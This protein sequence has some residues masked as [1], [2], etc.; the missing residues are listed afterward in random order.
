MFRGAIQDC[1][2][3]KYKSF[4]AGGWAMDNAALYTLFRILNDIKPRN[5]LEFGLG[6]SSKLIHQYVSY[7]ND[8]N[9][10]TVEHDEEWIKFFTNGLPGEIRLNISKHELISI[11]YNGFE[12]QSYKNLKSIT[13]NRQYD[14]IIVD[15]P[16]GS[17]H[18]SRSQII[19]LVP[20]GLTNTFCI[21]M[22]DSDRKGENETVQEICKIL[23]E[24]KIK[25]CIRKYDGEKN[26]H[27]IICSEN[28]KFLTSLL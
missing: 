1:E 24:N 11:N 6:Q 22:D 17:E 26:H 16:F 7:F 10:I 21:F 20:N 2:W 14:L 27:T 9:A 23:N 15:G 5:I 19:D 8:Y 13:S 3:L 4:S 25:Y 12:T 18:Y 28:L